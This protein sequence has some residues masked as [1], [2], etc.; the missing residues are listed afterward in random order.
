MNGQNFHPLRVTVGGLFLV[1]TLHIQAA[2][3]SFQCDVARG[4]NFTSDT[5]T[6]V[7]YITSLTIGNSSLR[8]DLTVKDPTGGNTIQAVAVL[9]RASWNGGVNDPLNFGGQVS[10]ANKQT[11]AML[12]QALNNTQV[13]IGFSVFSYDPIA[14]KYFKSFGSPT[15]TNLRGLVAKS[16]TTSQLTVASAPGSEV[17]NPQNFAI[18]LMVAPQ[19]ISQTLQLATS[20]ATS[21]VKAWGMTALQ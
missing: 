3:I 17:S 6:T 21:I 11:I 10:T 1:A 9:S 15:S 7:G 8:G 19:S 13:Q 16:G 4:F 18:S 12:L 20:P 2:A 14:K 5:Q